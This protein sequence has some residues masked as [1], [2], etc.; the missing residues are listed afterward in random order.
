MEKFFIVEIFSVEIMLI[1][2]ICLFMVFYLLN[3]LLKFNYE[4]LIIICAFMFFNLLIINW[5]FSI[6]IKGTQFIIN[7]YFI[8]ND[9]IFWVKIFIILIVLCYLL[10][11]YNY[12][13]IK[14]DIPIFEYIILILIAL[15]SVFMIISGNNLFLIFVFMELL[16]LCIYCLLGINKESNRG[17]ES[18]FKYFIQ[19]AFATIIGLLGLSLIYFS[20]GTLFLHELSILVNNNDFNWITKLGVY[21]IF[22]SIFF[23]LGV[24]PLHSWLPEVYEGAILITLIFIATIPKVGYVMLFFKLYY[25]FLFFIKIFCL[26]IISISIIYGSI[27]ALYQTSFRRLLAY[28]SMGHIGLLLFAISNISINTIVG[29]FY[30]LILYIILMLFIFSFMF[31]LFEVNKEGLIMIDEISQI[32]LKIANNFLLSNFFIFILASLAGLPFFLGFIAKW[33]VFSGLINL[34]NL[35]TVF[36]FLCVNILSAIYYIRII[37]FHLFLKEK[38]EKILVYSSILQDENTMY[39]FM[40]VLFFLNIFFILFHSGIYLVLLKIIL[41]WFI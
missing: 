39:N 12:L 11:L 3:N 38:N 2:L 41:T 36:I 24:F 6:H 13:K 5:V 26:F 1:L 9:T 30:Y 15:F 29:G 40:I 32:S 28:G 14:Q 22:L 33:Y 18:A 8:Y 10:M 35:C 17:I 23:K 19:S 20:I 27:I 37:R 31:F 16:N 25:I 7:N 34:Y 4:D 21:C